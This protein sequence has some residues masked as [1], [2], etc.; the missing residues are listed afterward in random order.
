MHRRQ[1]TTASTTIS[2]NNQLRVALIQVLEDSLL[3]DFRPKQRMHAKALLDA[4]EQLTQLLSH[5]SPSRVRQ[6]GGKVSS[7]EERAITRSIIAETTVFFQ[8][9]N[10]EEQRL[11]KQMLANQAIEIGPSSVDHL[12]RCSRIMYLPIG[13]I[14]FH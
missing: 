10:L 8:C 3:D 7:A 11:L 4:I 6:I 13:R 2:M 12:N 1:E 5:L 14:L 9:A